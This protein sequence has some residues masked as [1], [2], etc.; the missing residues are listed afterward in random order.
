M[1]SPLPLVSGEEFH[2]SVPPPLLQTLS[3]FVP[4]GLS[5]PHPPGSELMAIP[6]GN[7][8]TW[9]QPRSSLP[10]PAPDGPRGKWGGGLLFWSVT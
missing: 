1:F 7:S 10:A 2:L 4:R 3:L 6:A 5:W 8:L 9:Q